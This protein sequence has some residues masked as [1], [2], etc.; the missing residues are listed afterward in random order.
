MARKTPV[1]VRLPLQRIFPKSSVNA[2]C[3]ED[4][5]KSTENGAIMVIMDDDRE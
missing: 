4:L 3:Q 1:T 5:E 2:V